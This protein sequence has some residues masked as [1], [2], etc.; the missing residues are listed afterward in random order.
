MAP[1]GRT[2][3]TKMSSDRRNL[4]YDKPVSFRCDERLLFHTPGPAAA[5][6][7]LYRRR[8]SMSASQLTTHVRLAVER[9]VAREHRRQDGGRWLGTMAKWHR[10]T[11][12]RASQAW[13][14][15]AGVRVASDGAPTLCGLNVST[16][17]ETGG[18]TL[19]R[20]H[21]SFP[22]EQRLQSCSS[23]DG[24]DQTT[25]NER[26]DQCFTRNSDDWPDCLPWRMA[27]LIVAASTDRNDMP[28]YCIAEC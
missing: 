28:V 6:Q 18:G 27:Q 2:I 21:Q 20:L 8:C 14:R 7:M 26:L 25:E 10:A 13:S 22:D 9:D 4:L 23:P 24:L 16:S 3:Q 1:K 5:L 15:R 19:N 12:E 17:N 11:D